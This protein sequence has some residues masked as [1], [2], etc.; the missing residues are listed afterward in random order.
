MTK[1]GTSTRRRF[2]VDPRFLVGVVLVVASVVGMVTIVVRAER[3]TTVYAATHALIVGD[4]IHSAD[5]TRLKVRLDGASGLYLTPARVPAE[6][7]LVTRTVVAGELVPASAVGAVDG[8]L[9]TSL[10]VT[11]RGLLSESVTA[12]SVVDVWAAPQEG[13]ARYAPPGII[14]AGATVVRIV[15]KSGMLATTEA[16]MVEILVPKS[17]VSTVLEAIAN[18]DAVSLV[19]VNAAV[20][21]ATDSAADL[22]SEQ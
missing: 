5:L 3:T 10:V 9:V 1:P 11:L 18:T 19:A 6:G 22:D 16:P 8:E 15:E 2:W 13:N 4:R 20:A 21:A 12:G 7:V 14:V 17:A